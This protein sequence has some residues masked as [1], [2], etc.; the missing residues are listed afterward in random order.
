MKSVEYY[1]GEEFDVRCGQ[2]LTASEWLHRKISNGA[3]LLQELVQ[4][5]Y[6]DRDGLR[7]K[8]VSDALRDWRQQIDEIYGLE[9]E[10][11]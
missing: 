9:R 1:C 6:A 3:I 5:N 10:I 4:V 8:R 2:E 7:I 11:D